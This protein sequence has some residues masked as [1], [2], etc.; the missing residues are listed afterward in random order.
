MRPSLAR[1]TALPFCWP[2][3][4]LVAGIAQGSTGESSCHVDGVETPVTCVTLDVPRDYDH[5]TDATL[6]ITA[7]IVPASTSRPAPDPLLLLA[8]GPGES[9]TS[10]GRLPLI[11]EARRARDVILFDVRGT[12]L[13][14]PLH[15]DLIGPLTLAADNSVPPGDFARVEDVATRCAAKLGDR[16][17]Y[18]TDREVVEDIERFRRA[19]GYRAWNIIGLSYGTRVAQQ[20]LRDHGGNVRSVILDAVTPVGTSLLVNGGL[21]P[22]AAL[23]KVLTQCEADSACAAAFPDLRAKLERLLTAV[24]AKPITTRVAHPQ[25]AEPTTFVLDY[26]TLTGTVRFALYSRQATEVLPYAIDAAAAGNFT[27][28]LGISSMGASIESIELGMQFSTLCAGDWPSARDAG[29]AARTGRLMRDTFYAFYNAACKVWPQAQLPARMLRPI[30]SSVPALAISGEWDPITPP[31]DAE[32]ALQ[33]FSRSTHLVI[34]HGPH[35]NNGD[36]CVLEIIA[37]FLADPVAGGRDH[38]CV[39]TMP[40]VHFMTGPS[41]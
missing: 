36:P 22:D 7:V 20:Y 16:V 30:S 14:E 1:A 2:L 8:G 28:L 13:S 32:Q 35:G 29:A 5:P 40:A 4:L 33:Q 34:P 18:H 27:P 38:T 21:S 25:T 12:G 17:R 3:Y 41:T 24:A 6:T 37:S 19:R 11:T 31:A 26:A 39:A 23:D 10:L 15:C 9:A